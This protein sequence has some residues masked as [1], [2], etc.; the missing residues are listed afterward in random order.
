[1]PKFKNIQ[2]ARLAVGTSNKEEL[3]QYN[4]DHQQ[5]KYDHAP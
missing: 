5:D 3:G 1:M 4:L 2:G